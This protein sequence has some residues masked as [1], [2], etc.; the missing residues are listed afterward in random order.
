MDPRQL[1]P[2]AIVV[3]S[4][5]R[6]VLNELGEQIG[7]YRQEVSAAQRDQNVRLGRGRNIVWSSNT[8]GGNDYPF[9]RGSVVERFHRQACVERR[10]GPGFRLTEYGREMVARC[11]SRP[12]ITEPPDPPLAGT[13]NARDRRRAQRAAKAEARERAEAEA[14]VETIIQEAEATAAVEPEPRW[15]DRELFERLAETPAERAARE[16]RLAR[17]EARVARERA[18]DELI[19]PILERARARD[20][21]RRARRRQRRQKEK[22]S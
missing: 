8:A 4:S 20:E 21:E 22:K 11:A 1:G 5:G 12:S 7:V 16:R 3:D 13:P 14:H 17:I 2:I 15:T 18:L 19:Y 10:I 9:S 6:P